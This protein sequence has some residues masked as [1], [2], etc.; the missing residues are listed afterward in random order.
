[1]TTEDRVE[2]FLASQP[3]SKQADMRLLHSRILESDPG[4]RLWFDEGKDEAGKVI[5]NPSIGYGTYTIRY[6]DGKTKE[7]HRVG[8]SPNATGISLYLLGYQDKTH[9]PRILEGKIGKAKVTSYLVR[10]KSL[11]E[12]NLDVL[13]QAIGDRLTSDAG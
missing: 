6:A 10:F 7:C 9:L 1:M 5:S 8:L 4:C 11:S 12:I 13:L 3:S 2:S